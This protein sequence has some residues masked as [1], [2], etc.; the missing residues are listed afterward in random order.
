MQG[1]DAETYG[2]VWADAYDAFYADPL[3]ADT[4]AA[5][6][7]LA[8]IAREGRALE[9]GVGTG[10]VAIPLAERGIEV[11]GI[12]ASE[13]ML[14]RLAAKPGGDRV[15]VTV[16]D[17]AEVAVG[18]ATFDL[19]FVVFNT[20]FALGGQEEQVRCFANVAHRLAPGGAFV[21]EAFVP[22]LA[23]FDAGQTMRATRVEGD[24][25]AL[26]ASRHDRAAQTVLS[27]HL[28]VTEQG[29]RLRPTFLR[30]CWPSELDL[31]ARLAGL[32][33]RGR[34]ADWNGTP[35]TASS[36]RHISV[37]ALADEVAPTE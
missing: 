34:W 27:Q 25:V 28:D 13:R 21:V 31:M 26:E 15:Q 8:G 30:Y 2:E 10:R 33:L 29:I 14:E 35:F 37:Y 22:D 23:R 12:D 17:F 1:Y 6:A 7:F 36:G 16:G 24:A 32:S 19:V 3:G 18:D 11:H 20:F 9:L 5:V 4:E